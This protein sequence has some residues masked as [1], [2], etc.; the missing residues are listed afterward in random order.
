MLVFCYDEFLSSFLLYC[1]CDLLIEFLFIFISCIFRSLKDTWRECWY[2]ILDSLCDTNRQ[3]TKYTT[4]TF[5]KGQSSQDTKSDLTS[6]E[7]ES[8]KEK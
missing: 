8:T 7:K 2:F 6:F 5:Q 1:Q 4:N 3:I